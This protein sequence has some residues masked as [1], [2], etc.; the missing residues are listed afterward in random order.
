MNN[1][2]SKDNVLEALNAQDSAEF[3][4]SYHLVF[5]Q[6][7]L[8]GLLDEEQA[9]Y[10]ANRANSL[11]EAQEVTNEQLSFPAP[12]APICQTIRKIS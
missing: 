10:Y 11:I 12:P 4:K 1:K 6:D 5:S 9:I 3:L 2:I 8:L 7:D